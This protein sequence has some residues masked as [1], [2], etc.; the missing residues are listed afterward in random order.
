LPRAARRAA[1]PARPRTAI[2]RAAA[3]SARG[4]RRWREIGVSR[5]RGG[6]ARGRH[7]RG[8]RRATWP[9]RGTSCLYKQ[10]RTTTDHSPRAV[11]SPSSRCVPDAARR[12]CRALLACGARKM[13][14][15][16]AQ[17]PA[18]AP[19]PQ[20]RCRRR[21]AR[22]PTRA[23]TRLRPPPRCTGFSTAQIRRDGADRRRVAQLLGRI[24]HRR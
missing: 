16:A 15:N 2:R 7:E 21:C 22:R 1:A 11:P 24:A 9:S 8:H 6:W 13:R 12:S 17:R 4:G 3:P 18:R 23:L 5:R 19:A 14:R 20:C 10:G